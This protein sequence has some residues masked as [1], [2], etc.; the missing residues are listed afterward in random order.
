MKRSKWLRRVQVSADGVGVVSHAGVGML[1][2]LAHDSGLAS[3]VTAA[4]C[5]VYEPWLSAR[6]ELSFRQLR[7][8][9]TSGKSSN[10]LQLC[11][12]DDFSKQMLPRYKSDVDD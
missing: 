1:R 5:G 10:R 7:L 12:S 6:Y 2:E 11:T 4:S 3:G 8:G 9:L